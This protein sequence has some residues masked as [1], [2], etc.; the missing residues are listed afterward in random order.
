MKFVFFPQFVNSLLKTDEFFRVCNGDV[1]E[2]ILYVNIAE[3]QFVGDNSALYSLKNNR[4]SYN[5][6][7][8]SY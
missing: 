5:Y 8:L 6:R 7:K 2:I 4:K 3:Q 1:Y